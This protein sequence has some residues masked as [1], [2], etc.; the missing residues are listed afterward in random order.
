MRLLFFVCMDHVEMAAAVLCTV[1]AMVEMK[2]NGP[3]AMLG[4]RVQGLSGATKV[5][6]GVNGSRVRRKILCEC[7]FC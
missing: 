3:L 2:F 6:T 5:R 1:A 7:L 4:S